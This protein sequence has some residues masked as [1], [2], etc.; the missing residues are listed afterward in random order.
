[1]LYRGHGWRMMCGQWAVTFAWQFLAKRLETQHQ[2]LVRTCFYSC[3]IATCIYAV[4]PVW[5]I[6]KFRNCSVLSQ[7]LA[8]CTKDSNIRV[9]VHVYRP[10][11]RV[12]TFCIT[13]KKSLGFGGNLE[14]RLQQ[15]AEW[16]EPIGHHEAW[17]SLLIMLTPRKFGVSS[18]P[19]AP[20]MCY[21]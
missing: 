16:S 8:V 5:T 7:P 12:G 17:Q 19:S 1:M 21:L 15:I 2:Q 13:P 6:L 14:A 3:S 20:M 10:T 18:I 11:D 4:W 9:V